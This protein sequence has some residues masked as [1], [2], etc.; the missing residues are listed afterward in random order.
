MLQWMDVSTLGERKLMELNMVRGGFPADSDERSHQW[1][2]Q[3]DVCCGT[4]WDIFYVKVN[5]EWT[6]SQRKVQY[7]NR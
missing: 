4:V 6:G 7:R 1:N 2:L 3:E 5:M